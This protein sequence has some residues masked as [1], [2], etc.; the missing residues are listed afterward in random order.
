MNRMRRNNKLKSEKKT[1]NTKLFQSIV[2]NL[3]KQIKINERE[4]FKCLT[5]L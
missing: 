3:S 4:E 1:K 2:R 5:N